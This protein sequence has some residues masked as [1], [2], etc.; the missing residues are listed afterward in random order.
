MRT[1]DA[2]K[3][4]KIRVNAFKMICK[5]GFDGFSMGKLAKASGVSP[6]TLYIYFENREDLI[7]QLAAEE[8]RKLTDAALLGFDSEMSFA[9]GLR[10]QWKN[11]AD[12]FLKHPRESFFLELVRYSP[13]HN[14]VQ[15][16]MDP[17][18]LEAMKNFVNSSIAQ[19]ELK[20]IPV[21]V[22]WS[23]AFAPLYQLLKFHRSGHG[24]SGKGKFVFDEELM[25]TTLE[26]VVQGLKP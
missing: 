8:L 12:Y 13:F 5:E 2:A 17:S 23:V 4:R 19:S 22:Y 14:E 15:K 18:Y 7:V 24:L 25:N 20:C 1:R 9:E 3:E 16:S 11:R 6:A 26:I 10:V 21:E